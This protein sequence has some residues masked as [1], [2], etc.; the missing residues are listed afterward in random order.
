M[1]EK[2]SIIIPIYDPKE[3]MEKIISDCLLSVIKNSKENYE[4]I[5]IYNVVGFSMAVN[6]GLERATGDY[7]IILNDDIII[8]DKNWLKKMGV[9]NTI[10]SWRMHPF[11]ITGEN[12]P[13]GACWCMSRNVFKKLGKLDDR[14]NNGYG[15]E[16]SDYWMRAKESGIE[17][18][19]ADINLVH[20]ENKTFK[21][22]HSDL[23]ESM[24]EKNKQLF[25]EKW[26]L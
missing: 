5:P 22:Y 14:F 1:K 21:S 7:L 8:Q 4:I 9:E 2:Y 6:M 24:T 12:V 17:M 3:Q 26:S 10:T 20:L 23:K 13:D 11:F 18:K 25:L 19:S 16:D 15:F